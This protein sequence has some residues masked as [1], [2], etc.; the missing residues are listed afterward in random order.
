M[1]NND[2]TTVSTLINKNN[3]NIGLGVTRDS[4]TVTNRACLDTETSAPE[5]V[6]IAWDDYQVMCI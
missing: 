3:R 5:S 6:D 1:V 4:T 2:K